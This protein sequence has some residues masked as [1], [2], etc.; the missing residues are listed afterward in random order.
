MVDNTAY[1]IYAHLFIIG[2]LG[3][4]YYKNIGKDKLQTMEKKKI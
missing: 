3:L 4:H 2:T 1:I